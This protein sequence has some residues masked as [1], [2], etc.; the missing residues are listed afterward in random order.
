MT[1]SVWK[2]SLANQSSVRI[3]SRDNRAQS[4]RLERATETVGGTELGARKK[5]LNQRIVN[6]YGYFLTLDIISN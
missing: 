4:L 6:D 1:S 3:I 5:E 2:L